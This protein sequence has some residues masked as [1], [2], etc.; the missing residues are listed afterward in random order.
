MRKQ[1]TA[2]AKAID[3]AQKIVLAGMSIRTATRWAAWL[4]LAHVLRKAGKDVTAISTDGVPDIY[5][6]MPG[7]DQIVTGTERRDF[8]LAI[9]CDAGA[10]ERIG[11]SVLPAIES[12]PLLIDIDHHVATASSAISGSSM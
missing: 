12:A 6:W 2:A 7:T 1:L 9:V 11:R 3:A 5:R 10:L 4:A 8:D